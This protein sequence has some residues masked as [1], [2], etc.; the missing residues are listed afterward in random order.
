MAAGLIIHL[1]GPPALSAASAVAS[2][3]IA[4]APSRGLGS[5]SGRRGTRAASCLH[6]DGEIGD[7]RA[8][9]GYGCQ[10]GRRCR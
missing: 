10:T 2:G 4:S 7:W 6:P 5:T 3:G 1:T 8:D 9:P